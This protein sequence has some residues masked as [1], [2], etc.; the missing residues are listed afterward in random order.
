M[1][2]PLVVWGSPLLSLVGVSRG[3][4]FSSVLLFLSRPLPPRW[5]GCAARRALVPLAPWW[6]CAPP[7]AAPPPRPLC[8]RC[9]RRL[10]RPL[11]R[12]RPC[13]LRG[14]VPSACSFRAAVRRCG[15][16]VPLRRP[17]WSPLG[18]ALRCPVGGRLSPLAAWPLVAVFSPR[19]TAT[20][21]AALPGLFG[22][23]GWARRGRPAL[24]ARS[25]ARSASL[26]VRWPALG[27]SRVWGRPSRSGARFAALWHR[28]RL[29]SR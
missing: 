21:P 19:P 25:A 14:S 20:A 9:S 18:A 13:A 12:G 7:A 1:G 16:F 10:Y 17:R 15:R 2:V 26:P 27:P 4:C 3:C 23:S 28:S 11:P 8:R 29:L 6:P 22:F 5:L 24:V